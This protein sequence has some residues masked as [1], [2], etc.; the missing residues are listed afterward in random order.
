MVLLKGKGHRRHAVKDAAILG[1]RKRKG[2]NKELE[3]ELEQNLEQGLEQDLEQELA[4]QLGAASSAAAQL[5]NVDLDGDERPP[6]TL[7]LSSTIDGYVAVVAELHHKQ[8]SLGLAPN[9]TFQ[10]PALQGLL[11]SRYWAEGSIKQAAYA[12]RGANGITA[13]YSEQELLHLQEML[14]RDLKKNPTVSPLSI[15]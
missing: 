8:H 14:L 5:N 15:L 2:N 4:Q 9:A 6:R 12:N 10:G 11:Q 1:K 3:L 7:L 13:G